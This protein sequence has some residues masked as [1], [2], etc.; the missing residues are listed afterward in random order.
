MSSAES[1]LRIAIADDHVLF[2]EGLRALL[3]TRTDMAIVAET[4]RVDDV[5]DM[6]Q[7]SGCSI[8]LLDL[9]MDRISL[10]IIGPLAARTCVVILTMSEEPENML[11]AIRTGARAVVFKRFAVETLIEAI[12]AV[13][14]GHV[15]L[16]PAMQA[17]VVARL[18]EPA[19]DPLS[20]REREVVRHVALGL[21]NAE[22]AKK[23]FVSE[24]T[25]K[26]HLNTIFQKLGV[27]DRVELT[28][29][30]IRA[31]IITGH[32]RGGE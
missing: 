11:A 8:L 5:A 13:S 28:L 1:P 12:R 6:V 2:R 7:R 17:R 30:A 18:R 15:W 4:A 3:Q 27:R 16:P 31:G 26:K 25:V 22:V 19:P 10:P 24:E 20:E 9:Q 29:A 21:R 32:E 14:E 23:L